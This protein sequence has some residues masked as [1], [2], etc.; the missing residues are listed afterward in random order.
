V[1][2]LRSAACRRRPGE[3]NGGQAAGVLLFLAAIAGVVYFVGFFD[4]TVPTAIGRVSNLGLMQDRQNGLMVACGSVL[5]GL[6]LAVFL[7]KR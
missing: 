7:R 2:K 3:I 6:I 5:V 4:S 1:S